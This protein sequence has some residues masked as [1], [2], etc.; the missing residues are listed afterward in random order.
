MEKRAA[1]RR[2]SCRRASHRRRARHHAPAR[3]V[4]DAGCGTGRVAIELAGARVRRGRRRS[5]PD[6]A[7]RSPQEGAEAR[8]GAERSRRAATEARVRRRG[9]RRQRDALRR[10]RHGG[11]RARA[12]HLAPRPRRSAGRGVPAHGAARARRVR[13][14][15]RRRRSRTGRAVRDVGSRTVHRWRLRGER[16]PSTPAD[17]PRTPP[18]PIRSGCRLCV[19]VAVV[20]LLAAGCREADRRRLD[21]LHGPGRHLAT[22]TTTTTSPPT[23]A[24]RAPISR[25]LG[26]S[27]GLGSLPTSDFEIE[28]DA[29]A[30][31]D[32]RW[33]RVDFDWSVIQAAGPQSYDWSRTDRLVDGA[34]ARHLSIIAL[35]TYTP[36]WARPSGTGDKNPPTNPDDFARFVSTAAQRY[37]PLGVATWEIWNEPNVSTFWYPRPDPERYTA[38]LV[39]AS[40]AIRAVEPYATVISGGLAPASDAANGSQVDVRTFLT[41]VYAAGG[42]RAFDAVGLHPYSF[43]RLPTVPRRLQH[44]PQ[45]PRPLSGDGRP[46]RRGQADLGHRDRRADRKAAAARSPRPFRRRSSLRPTSSGPRGASPD[47]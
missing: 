23:T 11:R 29:I 39:R 17:V 7:R 22:S 10:A 4:L 37:A 15:G 28:L 40:A 18:T 8:V 46:R 13:R 21:D 24:P 47:R 43:P 41:R 35:M 12:H 34:R 26:R 42:G 16:P 5:R 25:T 20:V 36:V 44:V 6:D 33:L 2:S 14:R 3:K 19:A 1:S 27:L 9:A 30:A 38:L 32:V 45:D 31:T